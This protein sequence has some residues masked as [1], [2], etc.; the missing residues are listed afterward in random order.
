MAKTEVDWTKITRQE[1]QAYEAVRASGVTNM[2][3]TQLVG[4]FSRLDQGTIFAIM[5]HYSDLNIKYP[6]I[7]KER[8]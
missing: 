1:F 7:R 5:E 3:A 4:K 6:G 2:W 8:R